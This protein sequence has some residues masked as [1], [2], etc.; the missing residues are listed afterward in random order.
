VR[1]LLLIGL[2]GGD[3]AERAEIA[4]RDISE[5]VEFAWMCE[6]AAQLV[7]STDQWLQHFSRFTWRMRQGHNRGYSSKLQCALKAAEAEDG[8]TQ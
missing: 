2:M 6:T 5:P 8:S 3:G 7:D 4:T 1:R